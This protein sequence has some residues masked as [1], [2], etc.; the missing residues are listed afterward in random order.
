MF[1]AELRTGLWL[2]FVLVTLAAAGILLIAPIPFWDR[3]VTLTAIA[4]V[5]IAVT[6]ITISISIYCDSSIEWAS[7]LPQ[8]RGWV[9]SAMVGS[10]VVAA[11]AALVAASLAQAALFWLLPGGTGPEARRL[12]LATIPAG[13]WCAIVL[14]PWAI[15]ARLALGRT[16]APWL[17]LGVA[18]AS[19]RLPDASSRSLAAALAWVL[20]GIHV[21][22]SHLAASVLFVPSSWLYA[23]THAACITALA[24]PLLRRSR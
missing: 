10:R 9:L 14:V 1:R 21:P 19:T 4:G 24:T 12:L 22:A 17:V 5:N 2:K 11:S 23:V 16:A 6:V 20:P 13:C 7:E 8:P 15:L 3:S 18:L